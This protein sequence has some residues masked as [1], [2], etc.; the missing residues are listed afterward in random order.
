M[1]QT[2]ERDAKN[3]TLPMV[4]I[5]Q[6]VEG[7]GLKAGYPTTFIRLYNCNLR[8]TW[9]DTKYSYAPYPPEFTATIGEIVEQV[10]RYGNPCICLTGGEPLLYE[11]KALAL[12]QELAALPSVE[13]IHIE[14]NGAIR[15]DRF[16]TWRKSVPEGK[17]VRFVMDYKLTSSGE[18]E[19]M[20]E[21]NFHL[22][23]ERD[24][25]KF[26]IANR[27][28]FDEAMEVVRRCVRKGNILF[29][30]V[31]ETLPPSRLVEWILAGENKRIKLNL[32]THKYIWDPNKRG[33]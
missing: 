30:P 27:E 22:M 25:I 24:E 23:D 16:D 14:T 10:E 11:E 33:V 4:E 28:E 17:K 21:S 6:T 3:L 26:V 9:C 32:Q 20:I 13:D 1:M 18:R 15:L 5:F 8:C 29:S 2:H 7:E 19:K 31:W 12:I